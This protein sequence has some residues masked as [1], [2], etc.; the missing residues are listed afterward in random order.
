MLIALRRQASLWSAALWEAT[1]C[2]SLGGRDA[3]APKVLFRSS[4]LCIAAVSFWAWAYV[5]FAS[6]IWAVMQVLAMVGTFGLVLGGFQ[7]LGPLAGG[8]SG[9]GS[10]AAMGNIASGLLHVAQILI[11]VA[12]FVAA[13]Y[14]LVYLFVVTSSVRLAMRP[15]LSG[16]AVAQVLK[17][18]SPQ[19]MLMLPSTSA[20]SRSVGKQV[21]VLLLC[22]CVPLL[23]GVVLVLT[24]C[25]LNVRL[26]YVAMAKRT[27]LSVSA[28]TAIRW[29]WRTLFLVGFFLTILL[30]V[31][32]VNLLVPAMLY[33]ST[34]HLLCRQNVLRLA[35]T[36]EPAELSGLNPN[37]V[38]PPLE[39]SV[40]S[41]L[42]T[43]SAS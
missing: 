17:G 38:Q 1:K 14:V 41:Q 37:S 6:E 27:S 24:A 31:P 40:A 22:L 16:P 3:L 21:L 5:H 11:I 32:V 33:T 28:L 42:T 12:A 36:T 13:L 15:L 19:Q 7:G 29:R 34:L 43:S 4:L 30:V 39:S 20:A 25:Y 9:G 2:L 8:G 26:I 23:A 18:Y 10:V 35:G